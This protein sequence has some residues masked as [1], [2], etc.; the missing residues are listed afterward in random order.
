MLA[1]LAMT[2]VSM[3]MYKPSRQQTAPSVTMTEFKMSAVKIGAPIPAIFGIA[4]I[5]GLIIE[6]GDWKVIQHVKTSS[7]KAGK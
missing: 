2:A 7:M 1:S 3:L 5:S 4:R 6:W